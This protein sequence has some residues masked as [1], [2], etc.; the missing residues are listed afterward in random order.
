[1]GSVGDSYDNAMCESFFATLE[2]ELLD[3]RSFATVAEGRRE[4]FRF[5]EGFYNT[6][7]LHS[8]RSSPELCVK[9]RGSSSMLRLGCVGDLLRFEKREIE[10][11]AFAPDRSSPQSNRGDEA[12]RTGSV[13]EGAGAPDPTLDLGVQ[14]L[15]AV[16]DA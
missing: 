10:V 6:R 14:A 3:R 2:C 15:E 9:V 5:I 8:A 11:A 12:E 1:M 16:R 13:G 4:V 7:R